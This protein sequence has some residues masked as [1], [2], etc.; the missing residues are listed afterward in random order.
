MIRSVAGSPLRAARGIERSWPLP[1]ARDEIAL[2]MLSLAEG[3][4]F[5]PVQIQKALF[6][7]SDKAAS[8]FR[9]DSRYNF[10]PY[11]YGPFDW[12]VYAD[13]ESLERRGLAEINQQEATR[14]RTYSA[15]QQGLTEGRRLATELPREQRELLKKI[16]GLVRSLS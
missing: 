14:W 11:D 7:A 10:E 4:P 2:V 6:L 8:A 15:S 9:R 5:T 12:Q 13:A 3:E 1:L 16:V